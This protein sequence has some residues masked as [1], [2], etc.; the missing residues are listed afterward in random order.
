M[1]ASERLHKDIKDGESQ[2]QR[3]AGL[4]ESTGSAPNRTNEGY[5]GP[6]TPR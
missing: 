5:Q 3:S 1:E 2:D 4:P 6:G